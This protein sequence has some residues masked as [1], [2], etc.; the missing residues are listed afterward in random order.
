M[1]DSVNRESAVSYDV[2]NRTSNCS[3]T[4]KEKKGRRADG[5][6]GMVESRRLGMGWAA[7]GPTVSFLL[8]ESVI[9]EKRGPGM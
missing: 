2:W 1:H 8:L 9:Q 6:D 5:V 7:N 3:A 4:T